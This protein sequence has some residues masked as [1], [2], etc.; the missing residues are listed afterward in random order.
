MAAGRAAAHDVC[1]RHTMLVA[2]TRVVAR[3]TCVVIFDV[4]LMGPAVVVVVKE[5]DWVGAL[6]GALLVTTLVF[7]VV[8]AAVA[9][10][11]LWAGRHTGGSWKN[12]CW[13]C[14]CWLARK[15]T[16]YCRPCILAVI[17]QTVCI[18]VVSW[19]VC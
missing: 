19:S 6:M 18:T 7:F 5:M 14:C 16:R 8:P 3:R 10:L 11:L 4:E 13:G 17:C 2:R 12:C 9:L 15:A 1:L